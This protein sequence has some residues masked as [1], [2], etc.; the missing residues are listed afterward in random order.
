MA[1]DAPD[2]FAARQDA[3]HGADEPLPADIFELEVSELA[4]VRGGAQGDWRPTSPRARRPARQLL[5]ALAAAATLVGL[6]ALLVGGVM[7]Q[8]RTSHQRA[9][10]GGA[11]APSLTP[12]GRSPAPA[13][14]TPSDPAA[15][16]S[17][18]RQCADGVGASASLVYY[19]SPALG[20]YPVWVTGFDGDAAP[21]AVHFGLQFYRAYTPAG[22]A[23][24][25]LLVVPPGY[26]QA[27][28]VRGSRQ[29]DGAPLTLETDPPAGAA[30]ALSLDPRQ[31]HWR[32]EGWSEWPA[33]VFLP[34]AGCYYLEAHWPGGAWRL[35]FAAG[36]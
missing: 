19:G 28:T 5:R 12:L 35:S 8:Q 6:L 34:A 30:A 4:H 29:S 18:P 36:I 15:L 1:Q 25:I 10:S 32:I 14:L 33:W 26:A 11:T 7:G 27:I 17:L 31:P 24:R 13:E 16:A 3:H 21:P 22:W 9:A 20:A 2:G 23:W